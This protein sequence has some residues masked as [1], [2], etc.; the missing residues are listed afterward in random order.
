[1]LLT[2]LCACVGK[3]LLILRGFSQ[4]CA[5]PGCFYV[6]WGSSQNQTWTSHLQSTKRGASPLLVTPSGGA[7]WLL[8]AL[9]LGIVSGSAWEGIIR[10]A[11]DQTWVSSMQGK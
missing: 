5:V 10:V 6:L 3:H 2:L 11:K 8:L 4:F 1:M 9:H 7:Q